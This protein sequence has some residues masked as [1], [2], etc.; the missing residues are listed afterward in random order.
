MKI[1]IL[2]CYGGILPGHRTTNFLI[3][4]TIAIDAGALVHALT[5]EE[6]LMVKHIF[7]SHTHLD[8]TNS[9]PFLIDNV[10]GITPGQIHVYSIASVIESIRRHIF[11]D[12]TWPDFSRIP[13]EEHSI[14][15]FH[16]L[17]PGIAV[18][19]EGVKVTAVPVNH[20]VPCI[21]FLCDD[22]ESAILYSA[23]TGPCP[24]LYEV[25]NRTANLKM[26]ITEVSFPNN[27]GDIAALSKHLTPELLR[28][29]LE[30]LKRPV[31]VLLYHLKPPYIDVLHGEIEALNL[32]RV[33]C[34]DQD[35][36]YE[37]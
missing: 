10:F 23:D 28:G 4:D 25:A 24:H 19:V 12:E 18:E 32:P 37:V 17:E 26:L 2:G 29:E 31:D 3:N 21:G 22:G 36:V 14:L 5:F 6:Q 20:I 34:L 30:Q 35:A 11:N 9:L 8:H 13:D 15:K 1:K 33:K 7:I 27:M 16:V